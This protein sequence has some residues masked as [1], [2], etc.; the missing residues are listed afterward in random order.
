M[1]ANSQIDA[2]VCMM[3]NSVF[4]APKGFGLKPLA[5][6]AKTSHKPEEPL[7]MLTTIQKL[8]GLDVNQCMP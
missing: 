3:C 1:A 2:A 4:A 5:K 6:M 7:R 8:L